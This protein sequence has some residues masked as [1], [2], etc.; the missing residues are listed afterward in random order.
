M[1]FLVGKKVKLVYAHDMWPMVLHKLVGEVGEIKERTEFD[2][3]FW[4]PKHGSRTRRVVLWIVDFGG[5]KVWMREK[6]LEV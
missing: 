4:S 6:Y 2:E 5:Q 1:E 3:P